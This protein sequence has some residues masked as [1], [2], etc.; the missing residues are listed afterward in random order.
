M[1]SK[2]FRITLNTAQPD[3]LLRFYSILG[4]QFTQKQVNKGSQAWMGSC[5]DLNLEIFNIKESFSSKSPSVQMTFEVGNVEKVVGEF[6]KI[7]AQIM[8]EPMPI[9][10]GVIAIV[11]DP[12]GRSV[13]LNQPS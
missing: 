10:E 4:F 7:K 3:L 9:Q 8:V 2:L 1:Q 13:E 6:K 12:D 11:M 5:G